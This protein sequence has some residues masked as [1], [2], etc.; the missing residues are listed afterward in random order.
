MISISPASTRR[1]LAV[2]VVLACAWATPAFADCAMSEG[3]VTDVVGN[4]VA[5]CVTGYY[6]SGTATLLRQNSSGGPVVEV[7][8]NCATVAGFEPDGG[9]FSPEFASGKPLAGVGGSDSCCFQDSCVPQGSYRYGLATLMT[10][11]TGCANAITYW[12]PVTVSSTAPSTCANGATSY[13]AGAPWPSGGTQTK[14]CGGVLGCSVAGSVLGF[15][16]AA[17]LGAL[18]F[19]LARRRNR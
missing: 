8:S 9:V 12:A 7:S 17:T 5:F 4:D 14:K 13:S 1:S 6:S 3:Y 16:G 10:C 18:L 11:P 15:D 19:L 2:L